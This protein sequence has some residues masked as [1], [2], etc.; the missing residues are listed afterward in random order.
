MQTHIYN[1]SVY[2]RNWC[3]HPSLLGIH[4]ETSCGSSIQLGSP[5]PMLRNTH[6]DHIDMDGNISNPKKLI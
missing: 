1:Q 4:N 3:Y 2:M 5:P 6:V